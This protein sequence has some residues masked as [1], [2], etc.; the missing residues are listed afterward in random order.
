MRVSFWLWALLAAAPVCGQ[1]FLYSSIDLT[2]PPV[3][4]PSLTKVEAT[5]SA[6]ESDTVQQRMAQAYLRGLVDYAFEADF[7]H[8]YGSRGFCFV[9][10]Y[11]EDET[12][13]ALNGG[14]SER[15]GNQ[16]L[17]NT[18][19]KRIATATAIYRQLANEF[20]CQNHAEL[21]KFNGKIVRTSVQVKEAAATLA[22]HDDE[23]AERQVMEEYLHGLIDFAYVYKLTFLKRIGNE[24]CVYEADEDGNKQYFKDL[25]PSAA[26]AKQLI[27]ER[28][29]DKYKDWHTATLLDVSF[30][31]KYKCER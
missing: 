17:L 10:N 9:Q 12:S 22:I 14:E 8:I 11:Q 6:L 5:L 28:N 21:K 26:L 27:L 4:V 1:S 31:E 25:A 16:T 29:T 24:D 23:T 20:P 2:V 7:R 30:R 3:N 19:D 13:Y 18:T 15:I